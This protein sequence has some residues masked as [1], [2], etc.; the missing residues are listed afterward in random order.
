MIRRYRYWGWLLLKI[1]TAT[2][3]ALGLY[4]ALNFTVFRT[5]RYPIPFDSARRTFD[6]ILLGFWIVPMVWVGLLWLCV[7][8]Q[9]YR[10]RTCA[11]RLRMPVGHGTY[12]SLLLRQPGTE[13]ICPYG[14]GKLLVDVRLSD[15]SPARWTKYGSLWQELFKQSG[16]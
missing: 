13:Y 16:D 7:V 12:A 3:L 14:H 11:R 5:E 9:R 4:V 6:G 15:G 2:I 1:A 8:D 10:C